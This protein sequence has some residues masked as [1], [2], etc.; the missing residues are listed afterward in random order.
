MKRIFLFFVIPFLL[1]SCGQA[2]N[3]GDETQP[4][5]VITPIDFENVFFDSMNLVY[6]GNS[7][8]LNEVRGAP[9]GTN[10]TYTGREAHTDVGSYSATA[11]LTKEGYND[12]T[13]TA[14]L[15]ISKASFE[16]I[17]FDNASFDY[18]GLEHSIS[19]S[20]APSFA[21]VTYKNNG[22]VDIG[23]YT[24]IATISAKSFNTMT[25]T[26][27][28][29]IVG[30]EITG[31][32]LEDAT[33]NYDGKSHSLEVTGEV[34]DGV[35]VSYTNN[36]KTNAGTYT[37]TAKLTGAG[38]NPLTLTATLTIEPA[39]VT[40]YFYFYSKGYIYDGK[41]HSVVVDSSSVGYTVTYKCLNTSGKNTFKNPGFYYV[42]ATIKQDNNHIS[43]RYATLTITNGASFGVDS[44][45][46]P[47]TINDDLKWDDLYNALSNDNYTMKYMAG[48]YDVPNIDDPMP[49]DLLLDT[50]EGHT[51]GHVVASDGKEAVKHDYSLNKSDVTNYYKYYKEVGDD[52]I[53]LDFDDSTYSGNQSKFPK[54]AFSETVAKYYSSDAFVALSKGDD[55]EFLPGIN[56][57]TYAKD[58]GL[59]FIEEGIFTVL[60]YHLSGKVSS[61]DYRYFYDIYKFYNIGNTTVNIPS[62]FVPSQSYIDDKMG[63]EECYLGG[64]RYTTGQYGSGSHY[65]YY[66]SAMLYV[67]YGRA[68]YLKSGTYTVLP[69]IYDRV[70]KA[71]V[72][73]TSFYVYNS[74]Q[75]GYN[76]RL[77]V[78]SNGVYQGEYS[79]YG[80]LSK[81][82]IKEFTSAGG[83]VEYYNDWH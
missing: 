72:H 82:N 41:D 65:D 45:K 29:T 58:V 50:F 60:M 20:G 39:D 7:H 74:N 38:Y 6:D 73:T 61:G 5:E 49:N 52:I 13:L 26:A 68:V 31:V 35:S 33:F 64:V 22:Q 16:N 9:E 27:T 81:F 71:I 15:T 32:N 56:Y 36:G 12:K 21:T 40:G 77:L 80:S 10:I 55:G 28:L 2:S 23:V 18:D 42:E 47:L 8:I 67:D 46:T 57:D 30:K 54:A 17:V 44:T 19:V 34:P 4:P 69:K 66:Y 63:V 59:A 24:V 25:K 14:T 62:D 79:Q 48:Y 1:V 53:L 70:V 78:D 75:S 11:L 51:S 43:K 37:V 3:G 83:T 76:F